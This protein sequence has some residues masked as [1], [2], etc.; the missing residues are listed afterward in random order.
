MANR[1]AIAL[2]S[3]G[4]LASL[5]AA[6]GLS[7]AS[8]IAYRSGKSLPSAQSRAVLASRTDIEPSAWDEPATA[9]GVT[10]AAAGPERGSLGALPTLDATSPRAH[11]ETARAWRLALQAKG[12]PARDVTGALEAER[13]ALEYA[14]SAD[15]RYERLLAAAK[16]ILQ[17]HPEL[18]RALAD[19]CTEA[20]L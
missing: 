13:R 7:R 11:L 15:D 18:L 3:W 20:G 12:A 1:G 2:K 8:L 5:T 4:S 10:D 19:A 6:T 17:P 9:E 16:T 14:R